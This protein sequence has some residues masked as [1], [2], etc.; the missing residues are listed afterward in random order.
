MTRGRG[1]GTAIKSRSI[2]SCEQTLLRA[3]WGM[4]ASCQTASV[5]DRAQ[6]HTKM[7]HTDAHTMRWDAHVYTCLH[8]LECPLQQHPPAGRLR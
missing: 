2:T 8:C 5:I 4:V 1:G 7:G 3:V 6:A